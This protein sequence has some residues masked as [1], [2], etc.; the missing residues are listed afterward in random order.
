M[1]KTIACGLLLLAMGSLAFAD[2]AKVMPKMVGRVYIAPTFSFASGGFDEN[3]SSTKFNDGSLKVFNL[4]FAVEF[5][6]I[7]WITAAVQWTPGWTPWSDLKAVTGYDDTNTNG[8]A[9]LFAGAKIQILGENAPVTNSMFRFAAAAGIIIPLRGP[10]FEDELKNVMAGKQAT[11]AS[12]DNHVFAAGARL[13]FDWII[14]D[15]FFINL[16]NETVFYPVRQDLNKD[17]PAFAGVKAAAGGVF[18]DVDGEV[19]YR[20]RLTFEIEPVF[21]NPMAEGLRFTAGLPVTYRYIPAYEYS[22]GFPSGMADPLKTA[23]QDAFL[24]DG[25][26]NTD[27]QHSLYITPNVSVFFT[28]TPLPL[29]FKLQYG[30][31]VWGQ[32]I[33]AARHNVTLQVRVYFAIPAKS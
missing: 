16:Y 32:N 9:D 12:M 29:E 31:P 3:G 26:L 33:A 6:I 4:A 28:K 11:M 21:T 1:K 7:D 17:G 5:G 23:A 19:N 20:Y 27:P 15:Y 10:D 24:G 14:S 8:M 25:A 2:D 30:I 22:F 18:D 13:Y